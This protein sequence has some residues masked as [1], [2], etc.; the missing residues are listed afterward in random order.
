M[1]GLLFLS[2]FPLFYLMLH[3]PMRRLF[4]IR[5]VKS[6]VTAA[7]SRCIALHQACWEVKGCQPVDSA[8]PVSPAYQ[9]HTTLSRKGGGVQGCHMTRFGEKAIRASRHRGGH[10]PRPSRHLAPGRQT[11]G[12]SDAATCLR[13]LTAVEELGVEVAG[14]S[15]KLHFLVNVV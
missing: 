10:R 3:R 4:F 5:N 12:E 11:A 9:C 13:N 1:H 6:A 8:V 14:R 7:A 2:F 15:S